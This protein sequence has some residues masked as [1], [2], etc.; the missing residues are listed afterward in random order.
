VYASDEREMDAGF[1]SEAPAPFTEAFLERRE[2]ERLFLPFTAAGHAMLAS[3]LADQRFERAPYF[4]FGTNS[5]MLAQLEQL[6]S[7]D[8]VSFLKTERPSLRDRVT[9]QVTRYLDEEDGAPDYGAARTPR[10]YVT[11]KPKSKADDPER[12]EDT[13]VG[14]EAMPIQSF[15]RHEQD[16]RDAETTDGDYDPDDTLLAMQQMP[17]DALSKETMESNPFRKVTKK[18]SSLLSPR[19]TE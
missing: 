7:T 6:A 13:R 2:Q 3:V 11:T 17:K 19:K 9:N 4:A 5:E 15:R 1:E 8:I 12:N 18:L 16:D 14:A 10:M